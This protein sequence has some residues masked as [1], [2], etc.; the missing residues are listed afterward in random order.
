VEVLRDGAPFSTVSQSL[1]YSGNDAAFN[2]SPTIDAGLFD[3]DLRVSLL[4]GPARTRI[5]E[6]INLVCG[7]AF[8]VHGQSNAVAADYFFEELGNQSQS[9]FIRSFGSSDFH[10][11]VHPFDL[12]WAQADGELTYSHGAIGSWALRLGEILV[13][14]EGV[15]VALINAAVGGTNLF[16]H[17]RDDSDPADLTTIYGRTL[18]R[19]QQAG[20]ADDV[21]ASIW[22]QGESDGTF[23]AL[24]SI[25]FGE[26]RTDL[27]TD[28]PGLERIY[29]FQIR[30]GCD[31]PNDPVREAIRTRQD[32]YADV[33]VM[34]TEAAPTHDG[35]HFYYAGY[36]ELG[37]RLAR[38]VR[39]D[40]YA[41]PDVVN[42]DPP[43]IEFAFWTSP[44][45][46]NV[47]IKFR[48]SSDTLVLEPGAEQDFTIND[49]GV[50]IVGASSTSNTITLHLSGPST[51]TQVTY[52]GHSGDGPAVRN[53]RGVG[54]LSFFGSP[55]L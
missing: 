18:Y 54:A 39:R 41:S 10:P 9:F 44:Q 5:Q 47:R 13:Q 11:D 53:T 20:V 43:N 6:R 4:A 50:T 16:E 51:A 12:H 32:V 25:Y 19:A 35:C 21:R 24:W 29:V 28:Y 45:H 37:D 30:K 23:G 3:Y 33:Y 40:L 22:Y 55:I 42:I 27:M 46:D 15:P 8:L 31:I 34:S 48:N 17:Q 36:R 49:A 38:V 52:R 14:Q 26:L 2:L 1:S 7:D